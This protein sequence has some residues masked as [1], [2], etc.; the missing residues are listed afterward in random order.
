MLRRGRAERDETQGAAEH[1]RDLIPTTPR[2]TLASNNSPLMSIRLKH[3]GRSTLTFS[4]VPFSVV[5]VIPKSTSVYC[6]HVASGTPAS[7]EHRTPIGKS[8]EPTRRLVEP[9]P[10]KVGPNHG[11]SMRPQSG[12]GL[13]LGDPSHNLID[14]SLELAESIR[15]RIRFSRA[16]SRSDRARTEP[17]RVQIGANIVCQV[18]GGSE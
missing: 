9:T 1:R 14:P 13:H 15:V 2:T 5:C 6:A 4:P 12:P 18:E 17:T 7:R 11:L 3:P 8:V 10:N 16:R